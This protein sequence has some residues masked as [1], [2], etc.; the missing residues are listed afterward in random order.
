MLTL[1]VTGCVQEAAA[2]AKKHGTV[3][4]EADKPLSIF[5]KA[6]ASDKSPISPEESAAKSKFSWR[7]PK[8]EEPQF[9]GEGSLTEA[10]Y[11]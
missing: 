1:A 11:H 5:W 8:K 7:R 9:R 6:A 4:P 3:L 2:R 10:I